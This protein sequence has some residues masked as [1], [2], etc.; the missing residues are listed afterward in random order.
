MASL[1]KRNESILDL[2]THIQEGF[3]FKLH[4]C[5]SENPVFLLL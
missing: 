5:Y 1:Y 4:V 3:F 2:I